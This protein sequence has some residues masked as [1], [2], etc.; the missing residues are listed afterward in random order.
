ML[1]FFKCNLKYAELSFDLYMISE[2]LF[3]ICKNVLSFSEI[4]VL[5]SESIF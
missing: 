4:A 3:P 1:E 2:N 5:V